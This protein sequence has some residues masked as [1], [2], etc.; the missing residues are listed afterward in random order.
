MKT[1]IEYNDGGSDTHYD[2]VLV[3]GRVNYRL[4]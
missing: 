4:W 1:I 2:R 3:S